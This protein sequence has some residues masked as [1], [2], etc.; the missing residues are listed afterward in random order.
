MGRVIEGEGK[1][2]VDEEVWLPEF[3]YITFY[4]DRDWETGRMIRYFAKKTNELRYLEISKQTFTDL[5]SRSTNIAWDLYDPV[6]IQ[7]I[8]SGFSKQQV[9]DYNTIIVRDI[10]RKKKWN[11]F[12]QFLK[13]D[14]TKYYKNLSS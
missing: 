1:E 5:N 2:R 3:E 11:G 13:E 12:S 9:N 7:W 4:S 10:E 6:Q 8:I 14:Y